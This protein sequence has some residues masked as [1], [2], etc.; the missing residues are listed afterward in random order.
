MENKNILEV[1]NLF[2]EFV[3]G[4]EKTLL[5]KDLSF[6]VS[7]KEVLGIV[8][9]SGSGK[10]M[11]CLSMC[12]L[13]PDS[14]RIKSGEVF[15]LGERI[16]N[17]EDDKKRRLRG[18][19]IAMILQNPISCFNPINSIKS[20]FKE[21]LLSHDIPYTKENRLKIYDSLKEVGF[22]KPEY[23]LKRYPFQLSGGML[24]SIMISIALFFDS[25]LIIAD[26]PT[27]DLDMVIQAQILDMLDMIRKKRKCAI[28]LVTH[29]ITVVSK[30]SDKIVIMKDGSACEIGLFNNLI[31]KPAHDYSKKLFNA[32]HKLNAGYNDSIL[33]NIKSQ[34]AENG[35]S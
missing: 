23:I 14:I 29:D 22:D 16:D 15:F 31:K 1:K 3:K 33:R 8:G 32:Y 9:E 20:H 12:G 27:T 18:K 25:S 5:V 7:Q 11:T 13:L 34:G 28:I 19:Q 21:T 17:L 2:I 26:E 10:S 24:Q 4:K 6:T 35:T 30:F